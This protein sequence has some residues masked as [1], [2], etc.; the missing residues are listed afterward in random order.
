MPFRHFLLEHSADKETDRT[1]GED[2][3]QISKDVP[4]AMRLL[5]KESERV[6]H[7]HSAIHRGG[8]S[9]SLARSIRPLQLTEGKFV[10]VLIA[11]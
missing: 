5:F 3:N 1:S 11:Y 9:L 8:D 10:L 7:S 6:N 4:L 2:G